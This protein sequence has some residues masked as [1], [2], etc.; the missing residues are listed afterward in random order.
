MDGRELLMA[1]DKAV[2][3]AQLN[4][5][6]TS[7]ADTI[8]AKGGTNEQLAFP[9]GFNAAISAIEA[10]TP[11]QIAVS[12]KAGATCTATKGTTTVS[13]TADTSGNC[14]LTVMEAGTW[15]VSAT[16]G[17]TTKQQDV[18]VGSASVELPMYSSSFA[19]NSWEDIIAACQSKDVPDTWNVGDSLGMTI[20]GKTYQIDIIGK[21]HD[22]YADDSGKA[23]LTFQIHDCYSQTTMHGSTG[24][25]NWQTMDMRTST[26]PAILK[27]MPAEVQ[28]AI[29]E[30]SKIT[31]VGQYSK[32]TET[33]ADKLFLL[34]D[35]EVNRNSNSVS[36]GSAYSYYTTSDSR[37]KTYNKSESSWWLRSPCTDNSHIGDTKYVDKSGS[38]AAFSPSLTSYGVSFGF[39]F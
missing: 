38:I 34:S 37:M 26:L 35:D 39:C 7:V 36:E 11:L 14:T 25:N 18:T 10:R 29:R 4:A 1:F 12:T 15:T 23:P 16:S 21:D 17:T 3:S 27:K 32:L 20:N 8:R 6:L 33:T 22:D 5:D 2:D 28:G 31:C 30:V 24:N 13:G 9:S 19:E